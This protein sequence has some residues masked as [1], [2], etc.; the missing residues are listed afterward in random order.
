[1]RR[2]LWLLA[3]SGLSG[4]PGCGSDNKDVAEELHID[5]KPL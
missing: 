3:L 1:M 2:I 5:R 4:L